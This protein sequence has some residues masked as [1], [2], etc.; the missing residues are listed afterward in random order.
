[1]KE[2]CIKIIKTYQKWSKSKPA[3]CKMQPTCSN[4]AICAIQRFGAIKGG[5]MTVCRLFR[6]MMKKTSPIDTVPQNLKG[7]Y[8]WLM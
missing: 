6:C 5:F 7:D 3:K 2:F 8:K 1:M 4:Y